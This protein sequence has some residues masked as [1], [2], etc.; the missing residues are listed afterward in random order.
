MSAI[1]R[2]PLPDVPIP[3]P[4]SFFQHY[5]PAEPRYA[6][7]PA[8]IDGSTGRT[9]TVAQ[10]REDSLRLGMGLKRELQ[11]SGLEETV[12]VI[13]SSNSV[14][15]AQM[16]YGC[17]SVRII[18][19]LANASYTASELAH[20]LRDGSPA[21][22]FVHPSN[23]EGYAGA[24]QMLKTEGLKEPRLFWAVPLE[25]V[26][27][28]LRDETGVRS[29]QSLMVNTTDLEGFQGMSAEGEAAH[30]TALLCYSSGTVS[31]CPSR[32]FRPIDSLTLKR[33]THRL[34]WQK[35][36]RKILK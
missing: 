6:N 22:A 23:Y 18:T 29:Y 10:L 2:S 7:Y 16:F 4:Q 20:Q 36:T 9:I 11:L 19:S 15:F 28:T 17:Q 31:L 3:S 26:P 5:L 32:K 35:V 14:D 21:V 33:S 24:I 25:D 27:K 8:F 34:G 12:A 30:Q 1:V 13:Y